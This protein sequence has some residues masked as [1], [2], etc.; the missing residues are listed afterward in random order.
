MW[1]SVW[2]WTGCLVLSCFEEYCGEERNEED[3]GEG[4]VPF[5]RGAPW[6]VLDLERLWAPVELLW[7]LGNKVQW[8]LRRY[9]SP[10]S[11]ENSPASHSGTGS[12]RSSKRQPPWARTGT[13]S[14]WWLQRARRQMGICKAQILGGRG[15]LQSGTWM[16]HVYRLRQKYKLGVTDINMSPSVSPVIKS[17]DF[18]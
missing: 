12:L 14:W 10:L 2:I 6:P 11:T 7:G 17:G 8:K 9:W 13:S 3:R 5:S 4:L 1:A 18:V 16:F 15:I